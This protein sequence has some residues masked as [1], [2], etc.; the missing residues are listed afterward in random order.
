[1]Q[2]SLI[3]S[4]IRCSVRGPQ[5]GLVLRGSGTGDTAATTVNYFVLI[6]MI[7]LLLLNYLEEEKTLCR[8]TRRTENVQWQSPRA[9]ISVRVFTDHMVWSLLTCVK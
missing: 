1:M 8:K 9:V 7:V 2:S 4:R 3:N 5:G 6:E